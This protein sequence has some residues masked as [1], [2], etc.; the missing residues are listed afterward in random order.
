[1]ELRAEIQISMDVTV[2]GTKRGGVDGTDEAIMLR[3]LSSKLG[4][5]RVARRVV[6]LVRG[7]G[8][9]L[10]NDLQNLHVIRHFIQIYTIKH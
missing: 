10:R 5:G 1:M 7:V 3:R 4:R 9:G 8:R 6:A 2:E